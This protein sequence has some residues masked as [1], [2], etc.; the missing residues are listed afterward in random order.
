MPTVALHDPGIVLRAPEGS[1]ILVLVPSSE[2]PTMV[3]YVP[4]HREYF[5]L[6]PTEDSMLQIVVPSEMLLTGRTFPVATVALRPQK[7]Y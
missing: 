2:C 4:E 6:S 7:T 5:P 3:A 1:L